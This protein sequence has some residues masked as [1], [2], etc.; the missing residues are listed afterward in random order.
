MRD[1][2][3]STKLLEQLGAGS[4]GVALAEHRRLIRNVVV[5]RGGVEVDTQGDSLFIAFSDAFEA[6]AAAGEAQRSLASGPV[7]VRMG[8]WLR[9]SR[10]WRR[11]RGSSVSVH[12]GYGAR[13][14]G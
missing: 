13:S 4:Y 3:G 12:E 1:I 10:G 8:G 9:H 6:L 7:L 5:R 14:R 2:E 11:S